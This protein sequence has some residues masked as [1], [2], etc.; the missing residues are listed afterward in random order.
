MKLLFRKNSKKIILN[1][2]VGALDWDNKIDEVKKLEA[3][4][5][6]KKINE[7]KTKEKTTNPIGMDKLNL[8]LSPLFVFLPFPC[9]A[10]D[11]TLGVFY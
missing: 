2:F 8:D 3:V 1:S 9:P 6:Q 11:S 4:L 5:G 10:V 7:V